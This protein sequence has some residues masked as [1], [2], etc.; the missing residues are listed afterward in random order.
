MVH[1]SSFIIHSSH[2]I[3][4]SLFIVHY[5]SFIHSFI[6][7]YLN[8]RWELMV[9]HIRW[10]A[11]AEAYCRSAE[12]WRFDPVWRE[13]HSPKKVMKVMKVDRLEV[14]RWSGLH[15]MKEN[16]KHETNI[17]HRRTRTVRLHFDPRQR[18]DGV[19]CRHHQGEDEAGRRGRPQSSPPLATRREN[20]EDRMKTWVKK[21]K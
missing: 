18:D 11:I 9:Y 19:C 16:M 20:R 12:E 17:P 7:S 2:I 14:I 13:N 8:W 6:H 1:C 5:S 10:R 4:P 3:H 15:D 21:T